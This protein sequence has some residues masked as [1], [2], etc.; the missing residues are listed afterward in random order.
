[1]NA[2]LDGVSMSTYLTITD[3]AAALRN[4]DTT[5]VALTQEAMSVADACDDAVGSFIVRYQDQALESAYAADEAFAAGTDLGPLQGI[6]V[7]IKDIISTKEGTSTAQSLVL[8]P[9]WGFDQGDAPTVSRLRSAGAIVMGKL[10]TMEFACGLPDFD[11]PFPIP[12]NPWN[13]DHWAGGSSSGSGSAVS[14]GMVLG[15]LGTDTAGSIRLPAA[16]CGVS[17]LMPTFGRVPKSG[18]VPLGYSLDHIGPLTRSARDGALMLQV[19]A[20]HDASDACSVDVPVPD[21]LAGL[22]GDLTGMR[23]G[24]T[25][26]EEIAGDGEDPALAGAF[27]AAVAVLTAAGATVVAIELPYYNEMIAANLV[28]MAAEAWAYHSPDLQS[29]WLDYSP[30]A[31][32]LMSLALTTSAADYVQAQRGRRV[33]Q[34]AIAQVFSELDVIVTPTTAGG[35][36][37][38]ADID[39]VIQGDFFHQIHTQYWDC[40]G[41]PAI[42]V[43][44]GF[45]GIGL[46]IA[47]QVVGKPFD[48]VA[49]LKAADAFQIR[50]DWHLQV[51]TIA[52]ATPVGV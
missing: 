49:M 52:A 4:G 6:P 36:S 18:C 26:L 19:L 14:T 22:T 25:R 7:G 43:P 5:S 27:D 28:V 9:E 30:G 35:A 50:T 44:M 8:D 1:M 17:G 34:K 13:L 32:S 3:A 42:S 41:N 20:G 40:V 12:R 31:R 21:Y 39:Q 38:F 46:P 37:S 11:R 23:I 45:T 2:E 15:A 51:P 33:A 24:I 29:R 10:T 16:Y 47:L 48:E